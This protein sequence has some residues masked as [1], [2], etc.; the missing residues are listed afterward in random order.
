MH[1]IIF[2]YTTQKEFIIPLEFKANQF[3]LFRECADDDPTYKVRETIPI[4]KDSVSI[5][6]NTVDEADR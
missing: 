2:R 5:R 4:L 1:W 6:P 3:H